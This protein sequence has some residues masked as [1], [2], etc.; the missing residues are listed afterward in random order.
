[1]KHFYIINI[2]RQR[3][4]ADTLHFPIFL[5]LMKSSSIKILY[6]YIDNIIIVAILIDM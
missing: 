6:N 5:W 1:M 3:V 2:K 4:P